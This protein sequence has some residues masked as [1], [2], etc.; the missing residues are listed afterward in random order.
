[1]I[2]ARSSGLS[3]ASEA[4]L[5]WRECLNHIKDNVTLMTYNTWFLPIKPLEIDG[6]TLKVQLPSQFFWEWIDEHFNTLITKTIVQVLGPKAKL[7][8][9]I[10]EETTES[11]S[12][13][14]AKQI[15]AQNKFV[16]KQDH[17]GFESHINSRYTFDNFIKGEGNQLAR[18]AALAIGDNPGGTSFNPL[19]IYGGVGLGKTHLIQAIGNKILEK[20]PERRIIYLSADTFTVDFVESIQSNKVNEFS[21]FYR[22]MDALIIDDIQF[23]I[24]KEKTQD[25][26]FHIFNTLHQSRKQI[27]LSSDKPPKEL[28]GLDER[29]ISRFQWGLTADIQPPELETRLAILKR[30]AD[31]YGMSVSPEIL[32]YIAN[33]ITSNIRELEGCLI[34]LLASSS[35]NS[36]SIDIDLTKKTVKEIAT[37]RKFNIT[38]ENITKIVCSYLNVTEDKIRDKSRKKEI[39]LARQIAMFLSKEMTK[40]SLKSIGL[41]FGGRD[42]STVIHAYNSIEEDMTK[43][44]SIMSLVKTLKNQIELASS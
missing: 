34:K 13:I 23:L 37:D 36:I 31:D 35:L 10:R 16:D 32:E 12:R 43:D 29:L 18:A 9:L 38:I 27:V 22:S 15:V 1:M 28:K 19:F 14:P 21:S 5:I 2:A 44:P 40:S 30:K 42:H 20:Y 3:H 41:Q 4:S 17:K 7:A 39:V 25:L 8:Y 24:G 33:N 11:S 26:F 6:F